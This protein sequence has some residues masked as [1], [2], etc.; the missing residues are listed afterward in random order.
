MYS[1]FSHYVLL[2]WVAANLLS[3]VGS[4]TGL[5]AWCVGL[6]CSS[7]DEEAE[8]DEDESENIFAELF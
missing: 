4:L 2:Y 7:S 3:L 5:M 6:S 8:E 1:N